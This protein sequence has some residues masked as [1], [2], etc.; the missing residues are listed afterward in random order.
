LVHCAAKTEQSEPGV[1]RAEGIAQIIQIKNLLEII[2]QKIIQ[3]KIKIAIG[4]RRAW[5][6]AQQ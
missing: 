4:I 3:Y 5:F 2:A 6:I 1:A